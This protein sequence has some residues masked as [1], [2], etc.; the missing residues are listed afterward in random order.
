MYAIATDLSPRLDDAA[1]KAIVDAR[2]G[3]AGDWSS[4]LLQYRLSA[5][6]QS[7][8]KVEVGHWLHAADQHGFTGELVHRVVSR[9]NNGRI[10][11]LGPL[12]DANDPHH[13]M[14][15]QEFAPAILAYYLLASGWAFEAWEPNVGEKVDVDLSLRSPSGARVHFQVKAS[16]RPGYVVNHRLY[17]GEDR[18]SVLSGLRKGAS[19]LPSPASHAGFVV[20]SPIRDF[21][22]DPFDIIPEAIGTTLCDSSKQVWLSRTRLGRFWTEWTHVAGVILLDVVRADPIRY[23][24]IVLT[25]PAA[26][27]RAEPEWFPRAASCILEG[28]RF[29]WHGGEPSSCGLPTGTLLVDSD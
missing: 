6:F 18:A 25:N 9:A 24:C 5:E 8:W 16:D 28:D 17:D 10:T 13:R 27:V 22:L 1:A 2:L 7:D 29:R 26:S 15:I 14:F 3:P 4:P 23:R 19:Q 21:P 11:S 12:R 20:L